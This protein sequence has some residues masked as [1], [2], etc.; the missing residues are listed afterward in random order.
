MFYLFVAGHVRTRGPNE[1]GLDRSLPGHDHVHTR[2]L[3]QDHAPFLDTIDPDHTLG[4]VP[5][6]EQGLV[7]EPNRDQGRNQG[8]DQKSAANPRLDQSLHRDQNVAPNQC[9]DLTVIPPQDRGPGLVTT[10]MPVRVQNHDL[11]QE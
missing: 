2:D 9:R 5:D 1:A 7:R 3:D 4:L 8:I 10:L 11:V 6:Q